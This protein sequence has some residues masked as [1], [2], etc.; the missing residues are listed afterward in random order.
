M[1]CLAAFKWELKRLSCR[2]LKVGNSMAKMGS[3][4]TCIL[5]DD[6]GYAQRRR[7]VHTE[8]FDRRRKRNDYS[9]RTYR[10]VQSPPYWPE[11]RHERMRLPHGTYRVI[12]V[13]R[14]LSVPPQDRGCRR[15][16]DGHL[17]HI[18]YDSLTDK[19]MEA[20]QWRSDRDR[21]IAEHNA[22]IARR[23]LVPRKVHQPKRVRFGA[24][25]YISR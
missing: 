13:D 1:G 10:S 12:R 15:R 22:R 9:R 2:T 21:R 5:T 8:D 19:E 25:K 14:E 20:I 7:R 18:V 17:N 4:L 11:G 3:F 16:R 24:T 6:Y 23:P